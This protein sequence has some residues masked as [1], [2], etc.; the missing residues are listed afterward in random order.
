M[1]DE[2]SGRHEDDRDGQGTPQPDK[3]VDPNKPK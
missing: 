3:W 2:K 1:G